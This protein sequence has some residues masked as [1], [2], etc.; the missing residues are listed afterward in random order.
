MISPSPFCSEHFR[1]AFR[2]DGRFLEVGYPRNDL[3][4]DADRGPKVRAEVRA[5][6][7]LTDGDRVVLYAPTWREY[8]G[9]RDPKPLY[10]D[11][12]A[13]VRAVPDAVV[14]VRGHYNA[15]GQ[16]DVFRDEP[17]IHDVTRYPD[18]ADLYLAADVLVTDY[19][20]VMFD[21]ALTDKPQVL[22]VPDLDQY[23][24]VERGFY[25][26]LEDAAPGPMV[27]TTD[28]VA[29]ALLGADG[30]GARRAAFRERFCPWDDGR[31]SARTV[32]WLLSQV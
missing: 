7:G 11:A 9:V 26:D 28:E 31:A 15:T 32:D 4:L 30:H 22:L 17:R 2:F 10:L 1:S 21:F 25:L 29:T 6:L 23:R 14:L 18:I 27:T 20:S 19:S 3:L 8:V 12:E 5:A 16:A 24:D 13:L